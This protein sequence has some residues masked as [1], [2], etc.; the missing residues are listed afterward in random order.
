MF[1]VVN[2]FL[3]SR[4]LKIDYWAIKTADLIFPPL[5]LLH[6]RRNAAITE[7][8]VCILSHFKTTTLPLTFE[9]RDLGCV[10]PTCQAPLCQGQV[11]FLCLLIDWQMCPTRW[12][13][14]AR[15][16]ETLSSTGGKRPKW[17]EFYIEFV[18]W[19]LKWSIIKKYVSSNQQLTLMQPRPKSNNRNDAHVIYFPYI[20]LLYLAGILKLKCEHMCVPLL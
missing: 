17:K 4:T 15:Q 5:L 14:T 12:C 11:W 10:T 6:N 16:E 8:F 2:I 3:L 13:F 19:F 18:E 7:H 1:I 9:V 20:D